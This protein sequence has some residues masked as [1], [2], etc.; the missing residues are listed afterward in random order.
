MAIYNTVIIDEHGFILNDTGNKD[1]TDMYKHTRD[2]LMEYIEKYGYNRTKKLFNMQDYYF[3]K[4][5][6]YQ[7][8]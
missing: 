4:F 6:I 2:I 3:E 1:S 7:A 5:D 8:R